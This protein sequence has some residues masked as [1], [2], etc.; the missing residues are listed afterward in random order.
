[1]EENGFMND[2]ALQLPWDQLHHA[3]GSIP[4]SALHM[5]ADALVANRALATDL[6]DAYD[7]AWQ[8]QTDPPDDADLFVPAVF[9][10]AAPR[11]DGEQRRESGSFLVQR[12]VAAG[13]EDADV[14]MEV[15]TAAAGTVG[16]VILPAVLDAIA[17][18]PN[19][20]GAW[21]FLWSL[22]TLAARTDDQDLR[23]RVV[24]AC[25]NLLERADRG[26]VDLDDAGHAAWTLALLSGAQY[27]SLLQR[28]NE[29]A[30][31]IGWGNEY[32]DALK[33]LQNRL[34][35]TP[36]KELW[37]E[38]VEQW[39]TPRWSGAEQEVEYEPAQDEL[40]KSPFEQYAQLVT[41]AFLTSPVAAGL[42]SDLQSQARLVAH[43]LVGF[44]L[45]FLHKQPREW[46]E[47]VL[48]ELLLEFVPRDTP[49]SREQLQKIVPITEAFLYWLG[50]EGMLAD[51]DR[52]VAAV[53][54]WSDEIVARGMDRK[55]WGP[56]K[57]FLM[58]ASET[59]PNALSERRL[60]E[61]FRQQ[62]DEATGA[63]TELPEP[64][65]QAPDEPPIPIVERSP[66]PGRNDP[67]PCGSGKKYK[68]CHGRPGAE[69][70]SERM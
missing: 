16:P 46:D 39:L 52:L 14:A 51:A 12:L 2:K 67:C 6:F 47:T 54:T 48:R 9:A 20:R 27:T 38:P 22:T 41:Q 19:T 40:D 28:L 21:L 10:L 56:V 65:S 68:K 37:E 58:E 64:A 45:R 15:L 25:V 18:E 60:M 55:N 44:S 17:G 63:V 53:R 59:G 8:V 42:P 57:T 31:E 7:H 34:D 62:I 24:D 26:E 32:E 70:A 3:M 30:S 4:W 69:Q 61:L 35:F 23:G 33:L 66:K 50:S 29:R 11:L 1:M 49:A 13:Y 5:F 43:D 36:P